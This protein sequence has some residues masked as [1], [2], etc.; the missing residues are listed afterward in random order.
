MKETKTVSGTPEA[1]AAMHEMMAAFE[2][3]KGANDA[4]LDEIERKRSA[5]ALLEEKVARID[6]AVASAQ[7]R[8]DRVVSE[9]RR[10]GIESDGRH[11]SVPAVG[12]ATSPLH[13]EETKAAFDGY[14]KT[15]ASFG[16]ELKAGLSTASNSAGYVVPEQTERAIERRLMAGSPMREIATVRTVGAGVFRKPVSTAGVASGWVAETAARPETDPATLALLEFPSADLYANPAATQSLLDD[17]LIDLDEW[18][19]AEVEDAFAAQETQAFVTGDGVNKPKGFLS[20]PIVADASAV[21]GEIGSVASGAAGAFAPNSPT[22]RLI[23]LVYAPKAQYRPN[24][25][26]LMNRKTVSA[27][28]KFK[29]ADGNYI[30]QPAQRAG[31]TASLLGYRV[32]EI[33]T[34][35]DIAAN[36]AAIAF[37]D[38][39][40][41][42]LIVDRAGVRVLRDPYSAKPYV[43]FYTTKRVGG[44]VQN[45]D[46]IKVM[47]FA[48]S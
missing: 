12:R 6:Q 25:R 32:I 30:W 31:E 10:P 11:P 5:D 1:R 15:G 37:G 45:F 3:F 18:L 40:R 46:A 20:Y 24:G 13:G 48:A 7:A 23:D 42:Y 14:L 35:P 33:E 8:L 17:A 22:D 47:K 27:V 34:M 38:F 44:G 19:A 28:R 9:G 2:A 4:R 43:L 41:G 21:W 39:Q 29:D 36:S 16:L 26:F